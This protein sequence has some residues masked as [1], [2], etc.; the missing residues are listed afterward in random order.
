MLT[1]KK[2]SIKIFRVCFKR[3]KN[4]RLKIRFLRI[5]IKILVFSRERRE[6]EK[7]TA[8]GR[9]MRG[10]GGVLPIIN[11]DEDEKLMIRSR[12]IS[13]SIGGSGGCGG[14]IKR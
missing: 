3:K 8:N 11:V 2:D 13:R 4:S 7:S 12:Q 1:T 9:G 10:G 5:L 14:L 6:R